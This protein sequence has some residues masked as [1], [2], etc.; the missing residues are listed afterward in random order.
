MNI[1]DCLDGDDGVGELDVVV[2]KDN[3]DE[4]DDNEMTTRMMMTTKMSQPG[5]LSREGLRAHYFNPI[6]LYP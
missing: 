6:G 5:V 2:E 1:A 3:D 4:E